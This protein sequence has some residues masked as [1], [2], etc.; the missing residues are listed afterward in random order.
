MFSGTAQLAPRFISALDIPKIMR[1]SIRFL[2]ITI[3][4]TAF[5]LIPPS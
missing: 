2:G 4:I 3:K 1:E 5:P